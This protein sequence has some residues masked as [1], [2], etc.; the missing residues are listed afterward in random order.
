LI[1]NNDKTLF[2]FDRSGSN[3]E[4]MREKRGK[5]RKKSHWSIIA[6]FPP[7]QQEELSASLPTSSWKLVYG[8]Q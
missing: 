1:K 8:L 5:K 7:P 3:L 4:K 2:N 6:T